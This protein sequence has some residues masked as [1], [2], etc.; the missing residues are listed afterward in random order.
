MILSLQGEVNQEMFDKL[1]EF[2][3][4]NPDNATIYFTSHGGSTD[5][6][7]CIIDLINKYSTI[8]TLIGYK[9]LLSSG[10]D[11]FFSTKCK[12]ELLPGTLG[13]YHLPILNNVS[14]C[15][16]GKHDSPYNEAVFEKTKTYLKD[17][18]LELCKRLKMTKKEKQ[19]IL[20]NED[21]YFLPKRMEEF[22]QII[23]T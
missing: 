19:I 7:E 13:M 9:D 15:T 18:T 17:Q 8:T 22:L 23:N 20:D 12:H 14:L 11:V 4:K 3:N 5:I 1:V 6:Q 21:A 10:F 2:Y 16:N